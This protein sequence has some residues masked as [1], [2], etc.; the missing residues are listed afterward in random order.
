[1][2]HASADREQRLQR[3][4]AATRMHEQHDRK[5]T[6]SAMSVTRAQVIV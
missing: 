1:M 4:Q 6:N 5:A 2:I 3:C